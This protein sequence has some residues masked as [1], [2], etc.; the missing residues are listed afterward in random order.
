MVTYLCVCVLFCDCLY[1]FL[2]EPQDRNRCSSLLNKGWWID[3]EYKR[4]QPASF[5]MHT[6]NTKEISSCL[7]HSRIVYVGDS[8]VRQQFF[9]ALN[10]VKSGIPI[11]GENHTNR[12]F[13]FTEE[14]LTMEFWWDPYLNAT[15][16]QDILQG[17]AHTTR[18][19]LLF[20]GGGAWHMRYLKDDYYETWKTGIDT[21]LE[22]V[23]KNAY[24][25]DALV[26]SPVEIPK[27]D[28][29]TK[30]RAETMTMEKI[31]KMNDYLQSRERELNGKTKTPFAIP[32]VWNEFSRAADVTEDGLHFN[33]VIS[34]LETQIALNYRC[35]D[36]LNKK[37]PMNTTCCY[38][39]PTPTW[40]QGIIFLLFLVFTPVGLFLYTSGKKELKKPGA[41]KGKN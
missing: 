7:G 14:N 29:L 30:E 33:P 17:N 24:V 34:T 31:E 23:K 35:N 13:V 36:Q 16:T 18:P 9:A 4:W 26:L 22:S 6:Y 20:V 11:E 25:A 37:F 32:F 38:T 5:M 27:Y 39:Y 1:Y 19:S 10:L 21:V 40:Y 2:V 12:K 41:K 15:T 3:D 28:L 8:I